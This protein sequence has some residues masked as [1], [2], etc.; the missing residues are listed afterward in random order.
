MSLSWRADLTE[1]LQEKS[2][3]SFAHVSRWLSG[4][5]MRSP[6]SNQHAVHLDR[7]PIHL[8]IRSRV[9]LPK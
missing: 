6:R 8:G 7:L 1:F 3:N 2:S 9:F 5:A 4:L